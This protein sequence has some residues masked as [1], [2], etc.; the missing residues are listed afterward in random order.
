M[1]NVFMWIA[2]G[3]VATLLVFGTGCMMFGSST[4]N[5]P[6]VKGFDV[7]R[8]MGVWHELARLPQRFEKGLV[9]VT[10][11]YSLDGGRLRIVN[12]GFRDGKEKVSTAVG[13]FAGAADEGAFRISF[14]RPFYGDYRILW[15]S[16]DYDLALVSGGD[17]SSL[18]ILAREKSV[19]SDR[20]T[21]LVEHA[22]LL[23]FDVT[24]LEYPK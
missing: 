15:I 17:R 6:V 20:L 22:A 10:A 2:L 14:F 8:Y 7:A 12:R 11:T 24:K 19:P 1:N 18:W 16:K 3:L 4:R 13:H 9:D 23:G 5:L 21:A